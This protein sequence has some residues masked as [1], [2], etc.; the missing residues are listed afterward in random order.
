M[1]YALLIL[2]VSIEPITAYRIIQPLNEPQP[3]KKSRQTL[4][5]LLNKQVDAH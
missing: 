3:E 4:G 2:I 5:Q 1:S